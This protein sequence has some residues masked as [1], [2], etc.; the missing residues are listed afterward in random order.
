MVTY[1]AYARF[2]PDS[3]PR[4]IVSRLALEIFET[5]EAVQREWSYR[6]FQSDPFF[7][8][9]YAVKGT[10]TLQFADGN[11]LLRP[12]HLHL[13]PANVPF[14]YI[15]RDP[16]HHY[17]LHFCSPMLEQLPYF[18]QLRTVSCDD[19]SNAGRR[20]K[21]FVKIAGERA[22]TFETV[23]RLDILL[24]QLLTP[25]MSQV[26]E[27]NDTG[28][29]KRLDHYSRVLDYIYQ[30]L[31]KPLDIPELAGL[32]KMT[33]GSFSSSFR[34]AFGLPP[35]HYI[36]QCRIDRAKILLIRN[37]DPIK[38]IAAQVGYDN[39]FFFYRIFKKYAGITPDEY[40]HRSNLCLFNSQLQQVR[41]TTGG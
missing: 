5:G 38:K 29:L 25:F 35:K 1:Q 30:H 31:D 28:V 41:R 17:W 6:S 34:Q 22:D 10:V 4:R 40:R 8:L 20:M 16:F 36:V 3:P 27:P 18:R 33:R 24:R 12:G 2:V 39:E 15:P 11:F 21:Q 32:V 7:R 9:Y 23:M 13:L 14:R 37:D 26:T 19:I